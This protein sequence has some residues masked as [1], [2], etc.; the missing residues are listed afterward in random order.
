MMEQSCFPP[1]MAGR[2]ESGRKGRKRARDGDEAMYPPKIS[3]SS[4]SKALNVT[5]AYGYTMVKGGMTIFR[6][7]S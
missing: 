5:E 1:H 7:L 4:K 3:A 2:G 6:H